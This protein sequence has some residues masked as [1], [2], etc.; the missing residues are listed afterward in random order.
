MIMQQQIAVSKDAIAPFQTQGR[1]HIVAPDLAVLKLSIVNAIFCGLKR[2]GER[3]WILVDAGLGTGTGSIRQTAG[4]RFGYIR[5]NG[6]VPPCA[7]VLTHGHFDHVG[8]LRTLAPEWD[9]P[10]FAHTLERPF[11]D[12]SEQYPAPDPWVGGLLAMSSP[13]LPRGPINVSK[14]LRTLPSDGH[15]S[16]MPGWQWL[17]TPGHTPG[18]ISL[19]RES[20]RTLIAGDAVVTTRQESI[21]NVLTQRPEVHGPPMYFTPDWEA[22]RESARLI[23]SLEPELLITGH[24]PALQGPIMRRALHELAANFDEVAVPERHRRELQFTPS[25]AS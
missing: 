9:A 16:G 24:G 17:H 10:I 23:A 8:A 11:L 21:Y 19:W 20:D 5:G 13:L 6:S 25:E 12:G 4:D 18:H 14:F 2:A 3:R 7:I 22:A 1:L 15:I